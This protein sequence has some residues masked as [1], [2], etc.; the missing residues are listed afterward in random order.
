MCLLCLLL[1]RNESKEPPP[2]YN[3]DSLN[4]RLHS[5]CHRKQNNIE[6]STSGVK[7]PVAEPK[8]V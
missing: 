4:L 8:D 2:G 6:K 1:F 5:Q 7:D 3:N